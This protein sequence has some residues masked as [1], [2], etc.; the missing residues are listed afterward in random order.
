MKLTFDTSQQ[1]L[2][3]RRTAVKSIVA[4]TSCN[5]KNT[6]LLKATL[7]LICSESM[8][9]CEGRS[10]LNVYLNV[11]LIHENLKIPLHTYDIQSSTSYVVLY[12]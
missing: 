12:L 9:L 8:F 7:D 3:V 10:F 11:I 2:I 1:S 4:A 5:E 6:L